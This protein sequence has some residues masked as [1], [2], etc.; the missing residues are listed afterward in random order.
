[1]CQFT[2]GPCGRGLSI[3]AVRLVH[4]FIRT[5][6]QASWFLSLVGR[7]VQQIRKNAQITLL[8]L[9]VMVL[10]LSCTLGA[11]NFRVPEQDLVEIC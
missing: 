1:M 11:R 10:V 9:L 7:R 2:L 8:C 6:L 5:T 3:I 4:Y